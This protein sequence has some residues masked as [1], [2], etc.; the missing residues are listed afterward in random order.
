MPL[1][2][3]CGTMVLMLDFFPA[4]CTT[5]RSAG[6]AVASASWWNAHP[7]IVLRQLYHSTPETQT[8]ESY[9]HPE[10]ERGGAS[11]SITGLTSPRPALQTLSTLPVSSSPLPVH[12]M[13]HA[14][15][16]PSRPRPYRGRGRR[17]RARIRGHQ[18]QRADRRGPADQG[19]AEPV[20]GARIRRR[21][22]ETAHPRAPARRGRPARAHRQ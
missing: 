11:P 5:K 12:T 2:S 8:D 19:P 7:V 9:T 16:G 13:G 14:N 1:A 3:R 17:P 21:T 6:G 15:L 18:G 20:R 10:G 22:A 4:S